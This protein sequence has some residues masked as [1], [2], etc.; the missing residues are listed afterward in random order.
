VRV[1]GPDITI[2]SLR[3]DVDDLRPGDAVSVRV[4]LPGPFYAD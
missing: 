2:R 3:G 1:D 4:C